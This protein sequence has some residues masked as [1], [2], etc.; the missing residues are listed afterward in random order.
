[1]CKQGTKNVFN[2]GNVNFSFQFKFHLRFINEKQSLLRFKLF[3][4]RG[5][6]WSNRK[7]G[8]PELPRLLLTTL[9]EF[10]LNSTVQFSKYS[11]I[12]CRRNFGGFL[13]A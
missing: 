11:A 12:N 6:I 5:V 4:V 8:A 13:F 3:R 10:S 2:E 1:M 7:F 9:Y